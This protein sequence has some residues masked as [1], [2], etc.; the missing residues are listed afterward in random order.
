M[1][2]IELLRSNLE[3]RGFTVS[4]F[5]TA[6][7]ANIYLNGVLDGKTIGFGGSV[8]VRE[9]GLYPLLAAHNDCHWHWEGSTVNEA[10]EAEIYICSLNA[11]AETGELVNI[12]GAG[13]RVAAGLFG[14]KK[15]Y[16]IIGT[17][18]IA[19]DLDGAIWRARN[20]AAPKNAQRLGKKTPCAVKGDRCYDCNSPDRICSALVTY[21]KRPTYIPE[22]EVVIINQDL[23][24]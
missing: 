5:E 17:N 20:I 18:K 24:Y 11:V 19:P 13:N 23:G 6:D 1:P 2:N 8:T 22:A 7:D 14:P 10:N 9:M 15:L 3:R 21:W 16:F 4:Y 12:D